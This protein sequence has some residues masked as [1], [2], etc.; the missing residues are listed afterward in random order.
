MPLPR[1]GFPRWRRPLSED[2]QILKGVKDDRRTENLGDFY[3]NGQSLI[4]TPLKE[5]SAQR[6]EK[7]QCILAEEW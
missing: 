2:S 7:R 1:D 6:F 5:Y 3:C 4:R